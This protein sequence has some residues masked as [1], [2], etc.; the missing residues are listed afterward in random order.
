MILGKIVTYSSLFGENSHIPKSSDLLTGISSDLLIHYYSFINSICFLNPN[1]ID[2]EKWILKQI[3]FRFNEK[4]RSEYIIRFADL[5]YRSKDRPIKFFPLMTLLSCIQDE[6][7]RGNRGEVQQPTKEQELNILLNIFVKN[8]SFDRDITARIGK[9]ETL[10]DEKLY[11][12]IWTIAFPYSE[13]NYPKNIINSAYK[14]LKFLEFT[15]ESSGLNRSSKEFSKTS[16]SYLKELFLLFKNAQVEHN[17]KLTS[18]FSEENF[19]HSKIIQRITHDFDKKKSFNQDEFSDFMFLRKFPI[20]KLNGSYAVTNWNFIVDKFY[21]AII[22]DFYNK[23]AVK[24][25]FKGK[26][27]Q[28]KLNVYL[29]K[30]GHEFGEAKLLKETFVKIIRQQ[31]KLIIPGNDIDKNFDLYCRIDKHVFLF[32]YKH[33]MLPK[34]ITYEEIKELIDSRLVLNDGSRKGILQMLDQIVKLHNNPETFK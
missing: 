17:W 21:P 15:T 6:L 22:Y 24:N 19:A 34:K 7:V 2:R 25:I 11:K 10:D 5:I 9:I 26:N 33:I 27:D 12:L 31:S 29:S 4:E 20:I 16:A 18:M 1:D 13:F 30:V 8:E 32:E 14:A 28:E 3:L 23:T